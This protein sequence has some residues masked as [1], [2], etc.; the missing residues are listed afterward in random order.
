[1][2]FVVEQALGHRTHAENLQQA[3]PGDP[4]IEA[5]WGLVPYEVTGWAARLPVYGS[6]WTVRAGLRARRLIAA[7][8]RE[9][10]LQALFVHTQVPAVLA[11]GWLRRVPGVVSLDATPL[12]YDSLGESYGH[13]QGAAWLERL[14]WRLNRRAFE[15]ARH[16]VAWSAWA[17]DG[18]AEG[19]G[20][21]PARVSVIPPGVHTR[22][23]ARAEPRRAHA[24]PLRVLFVGG[25]LERKGG[26]LLLEAVR[27]LRATTPIELD[28]VTRSALATEAGVRVHHG[29]QG[30]SPELRALYHAADVFCLPTSGDCLPMVLA[31]AAASGL[32]SIATSVAAI[33]EIVQD[34]V[35]GF[36]VRR[37]DGQGL[38]EALRRLAEDASLR[39]ALGE[40]AAA[41][42]VAEHD[43]G[44]NAARILAIL[45][46]VA[47]DGAAPRT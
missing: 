26:T 38:A 25:D 33:P 17:R 7:M 35:T 14:K 5:R 1:M 47:T 23:W 11:A 20:V 2:G 44:R 30:N 46:R 15:G 13:A 3:V 18:L 42:A 37:G 24:G 8:D 39:L 12:Q 6:N 40:R 43:A 22:Q 27:S 29:M 41:L 4:E 34:G 9:A 28:L 31:E 19:Y 36:L 45:K 32:P 10:P 16:L 21:D